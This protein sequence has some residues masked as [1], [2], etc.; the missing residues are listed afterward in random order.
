MIKKKEKQNMTRYPNPN[1]K[2]SISFKARSIFDQQ[3]ITTFKKL[4]I[5][6][7]LELSDLF[8]EAVDLVLAKHHIE[9]GGNPQRQLGSF[10]QTKIQPLGLCG[11]AG[12]KKKAI[13]V[14]V[15]LPKNKETMLCHFHLEVAVD[16]PKTWRLK[17]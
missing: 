6:D 7:G 16:S 10:E 5:Q 8:F 2:D 13:G 9:N 3:K 11:F 15:Y 12:C 14:G 17:K 4:A 1:N